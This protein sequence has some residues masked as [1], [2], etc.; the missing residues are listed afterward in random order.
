MNGNFYANLFVHF[1]PVDHD[2]QNEFDHMSAHSKHHNVGGHEGS[3]HP[4][5]AADPGPTDGQTPLHAAA[6]RGDEEGVRRLLAGG[7]IDINSEDSN[8][9]R[10]L[11]EAVHSGH[12]GVTR[13][14]LQHGA[15]VAAQTH[16]GGTALWW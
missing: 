16:G 5:G 7:R 3:N 2:Q 14:L 9:W 4:D 11:H 10:P 1:I 13:L 12:V 6:A 8:G 15:D